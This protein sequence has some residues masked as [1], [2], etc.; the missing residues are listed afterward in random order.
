LKREDL[1]ENAKCPNEDSVQNPD[2][3]DTDLSG[4]PFILPSRIFV[5]RHGS[6]EAYSFYTLF[7]HLFEFVVLLV[8]VWGW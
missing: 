2:G 1:K 7:F 5:L 4:T 3:S 6:T 8:N